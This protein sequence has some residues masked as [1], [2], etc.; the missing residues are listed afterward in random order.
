MLAY[1]PTP[2]VEPLILDNLV[3][4]MQPAPRRPDLLPVFSFNTKGLWQGAI[5]ARG[6]GGPSRVSRWTELLRRVRAEGF[7]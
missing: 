6:A 5:G 7:D 2:E 4:D 1:Y 3:S